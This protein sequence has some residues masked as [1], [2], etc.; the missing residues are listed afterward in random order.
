MKAAF[1]GLGN[2]GTAMA[3]CILRASHDLTVW[4][5]TSAKMQTLIDEGAKGA[6]TAREAWLRP[7]SS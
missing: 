1:I 6:R 2:M 5:R 7:I 3:R 4:N